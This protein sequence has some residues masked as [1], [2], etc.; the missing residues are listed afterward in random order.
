[1]H[2]GG[3]YKWPIFLKKGKKDISINL[4]IGDLLIYKGQEIEHWREPYLGQE[5]AQV[6]LHYHDA[7]TTEAANNMY[8]TRAH[9][10]L[11][12]TFKKK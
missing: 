2:L 6:F 8:D 11:P 9:L 12:A 3:D 1:M 4:G 7:S 5:Y 10:G